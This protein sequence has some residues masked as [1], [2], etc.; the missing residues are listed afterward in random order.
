MTVKEKEE[1]ELC[2]CTHKGGQKDYQMYNM[3]YAK[4]GTYMYILHVRLVPSL[5]RYYI[6][7]TI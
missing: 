1:G 3:E 6:Q 2:P 4:H 7:G 5:Y